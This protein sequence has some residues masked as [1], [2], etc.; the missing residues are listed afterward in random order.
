MADQS[1]P[2]AAAANA[3]LASAERDL[4]TAATTSTQPARAW[5]LLSHLRLNK[6]ELAEAKLAA[7][8][9][10]TGDPYLTNVE[11][12]LLRL[13]LASLDLE[14]RG[15]AE[16]WCAQ[17]GSRFPT[18]YRA[19]ECRLWLYALPAVRKPTMAEVWR[20]YDAYVNASPANLREFDRHKGRMMVGIA[21]LRAG[22]AD[23]AKAIAASSV[24]DPQIDPQRETVN[25]AAIIYAQSGDKERA[26]SLLAQ[27]YAANPQQRSS[28]AKDQAWWLEDLRSD[29]RY[30]ALVKGAE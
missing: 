21:Y 3:L 27:W 17:L 7:E 13:F 8:N 4:T 16:K 25:L 29:P 14:L 15:E 23:S 1:G 6:G 30:Q 28:G 10:Y 22:L 19:V 11:A 18:N 26:I 5:N 24:A 9:A 2:D 12:T 20:A